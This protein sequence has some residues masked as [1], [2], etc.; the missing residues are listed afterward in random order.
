MNKKASGSKRTNIQLYVLGLL[1][2]DDDTR[3]TIILSR[4]QLAAIGWM[5]VSTVFGDAK[6]DAG[7]DD[8]YFK[9]KLSDQD[10]P[11]A[12]R[13]FIGH[14]LAGVVKEIQFGYYH[15]RAIFKLTFNEDTKL[16]VIQSARAEAYRLVREKCFDNFTESTISGYDLP[17]SSGTPLHIRYIYS[18]NLLVIPNGKKVV[19]EERQRI[20]NIGYDDIYTTRSTTF[21]LYLPER[22]TLFRPK[23]HYI[24][25]SVPSIVIYSDGKS[26]SPD[27]FDSIIDAIYY[28]GLYQKVKS[29]RRQAQSANQDF[30]A[31]DI[32]TNDLL[33][34]VLEILTDSVSANELNDISVHIERLA[35]ITALAALAISVIISL[36][37]Q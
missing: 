14:H 34:S 7:D 15:H 25:I 33:L 5:F 35:L 30:R 23:R 27:L 12:F 1:Y 11:I 10:N 13:N 21:G 37:L 18:Y 17:Q 16:H 36:L 28:G 26:P 6:P 8:T 24:R 3:Q 32:W 2:F 19:S 22:G 9:F 4:K 20:R 31:S 29:D